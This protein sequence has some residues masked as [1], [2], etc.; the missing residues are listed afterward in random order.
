VFPQE[1]MNQNLLNYEMIFGY[2]FLEFFIGNLIFFVTFSKYLYSLNVFNERHCSVIKIPASV[3]QKS[4]DL[5]LRFY[6]APPANTGD[7]F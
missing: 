3:F 4:L 5:T 1:S 6:V 7:V 2:N